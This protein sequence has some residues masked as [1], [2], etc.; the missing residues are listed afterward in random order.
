MK[1]YSVYRF[2]A[3][4]TEDADEIGVIAESI[5]SAGEVGRIKNSACEYRM[6]EIEVDQESV[7]SFARLWADRVIAD[8]GNPRD[9]ELVVTFMWRETWCIGWFFHYTFDV[10]AE[11][12]E[13]VNSFSDYV[14]RIKSEHPQFPLMIDYGE[15][16]VVC[17]CEKCHKSGFVSITTESLAIGE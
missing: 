15:S 9:L 2:H 12:H 6:M 5:F 13:M 17:R 1:R 10:A 16:Y 14:E 4:W 3:K 8:R 11:N 7:N